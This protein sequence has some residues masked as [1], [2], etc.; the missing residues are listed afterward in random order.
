MWP[1]LGSQMV[2]N[3]F[4]YS[5]I[6]NNPFITR[7]TYNMFYLYGPQRKGHIEVRVNL[8]NKF[9]YFYWTILSDEEEDAENL[10]EHKVCWL[11]YCCCSS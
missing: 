11:S 9:M 8:S 2:I 5:S 10:R 4:S 6:V 3:L 7:F 1:Y